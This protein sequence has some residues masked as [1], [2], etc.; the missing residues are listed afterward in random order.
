[1]MC[2]EVALFGVEG[3][4]RKNMTEEN[5]PIGERTIYVRER[6]V[7][8]YRTLQGDDYTSTNQ[9]HYYLECT[10]Y[11][12]GNTIRRWEKAGKIK[13]KQIKKPAWHVLLSDLDKIKEEIHNPKN[14]E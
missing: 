10:P 12:A 9:A 8:V 4:G 7:V 11:T 14:E 1:M 13:R 2:I 6:P 3:K 5:I